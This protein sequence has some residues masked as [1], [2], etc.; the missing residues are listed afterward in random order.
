M[1]GLSPSRGQGFRKCKIS[2]HEPLWR[3]LGMGSSRYDNPPACPGQPHW[4][5]TLSAF[6]P[7]SR[8]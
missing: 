3:W 8:E 2:I 5:G 4:R 1:A 7:L 6:C